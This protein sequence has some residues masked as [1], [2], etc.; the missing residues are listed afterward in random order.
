MPDDVKEIPALRDRKKARQ[1]IQLLEAAAELFRAKG[2]DKT[3][4][5]DIAGLAD[6]STPT[7]YNYFTTKHGV[8]KEL[9][10]Q[11]RRDMQ[12]PVETILRRPPENPAEALAQL[13]HANVVA[14]RRTEDKL[15]WR[16]MLAAI[17]RAHDE[18]QEEYDR[19]RKVFKRQIQKLLQHYVD[20]GQLARTL[21]ITE[22]TEL[23]YAINTFDLRYMLAADR[24]TPEMIRDMARRQMALLLAGWMADGKPA[25]A[26]P[27]IRGRS[28]KRKPRA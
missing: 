13:I 4:M 17:V 15:L 9:L 5:E 24:R 10:A 18:E 3:R 21:P 19:S 14:L 11:D 28:R 20:A 22:A 8:L 23:V 25:P 7:V 16:E 26:L 6:V 27:V 1:R 12:E 2:Y